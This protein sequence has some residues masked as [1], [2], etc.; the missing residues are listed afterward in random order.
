MTSH[1]ISYLYGIPFVVSSD[2]RTRDIMKLLN[3]T[4]GEKIVDL[5]SGD[6]KLLFEIAKNGSLAYEYEINPISYNLNLIQMKLP[7]VK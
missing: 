7:N 1:F 2:G 4:K 6:G 5:G 3:P